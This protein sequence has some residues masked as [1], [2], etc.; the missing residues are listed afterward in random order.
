MEIENPTLLER[1]SGAFKLLPESARTL[2]VRLAI[3]LVAAISASLLVQCAVYAYAFRHGA[4]IPLEGVSFIAFMGALIGFV[5]SLVSL[6]L[7]QFIP[8]EVRGF[9]R[10]IFSLP[11]NA[12][13]IRRRLVATN[14]IYLG[15][16]LAVGAVMIA[17]QTG[18]GF[19]FL[20]PEDREDLWVTVR[21]VGVLLLWMALVGCLALNF[22]ASDK[23][24]HRALLWLFVVIAVG[25]L[26]A[27]L[28]SP[29][30]SFLRGIRYGGGL[31]VELVLDDKSTIKSC[32]FLMSDSVVTTYDADTTTFTEIPRAEVARLRY[33][34][35]EN[36]CDL[37]LPYSK[38]DEARTPTG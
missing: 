20:K 22:Q 5:L 8:H 19:V 34:P 2:I 6:F 7:F 38:H 12:E 4:R 28:T 23:R 24:W 31:S 32:L 3:S 25:T 29:F 27:L 35:S 13:F 17:I 36:A 10:D 1:A 18:A 26:W 9:R 14:V 21:G 33:S 30:A 11:E 37:P 16:L 15:A